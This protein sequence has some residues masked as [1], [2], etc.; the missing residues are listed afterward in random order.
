MEGEL[1]LQACFPVVFGAAQQLAGVLAQGEG[2]PAFAFALLVVV[3]PSLG[4]LALALA[5]E[6]P[7]LALQAG[8]HSVDQIVLH[9][10]GV[11]LDALALTHLIVG[12]TL[13]TALRRDFE[14]VRDHA[15]VVGE[16]ERGLA[17]LAPLGT[18][19]S[20]SYY[21]ALPIHCQLEG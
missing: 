2:R 13:G 17:L 8:R 3:A 16:L 12:F 10:V 6:K 20:T 7:I 18:V 21:L 9:A 5:E 14:A 1:A 11:L 4:R 19:A 15:L